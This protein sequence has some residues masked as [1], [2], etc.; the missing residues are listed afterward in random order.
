[1]RIVFRPVLPSDGDWRCADEN[2]HW[3]GCGALLS[4]LASNSASLGRFCTSLGIVGVVRPC[5]GDWE[6]S[7][8]V[9]LL[10]AVYSGASYT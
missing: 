7:A 1:M 8:L 9:G 10:A 2:L 6:G 3:R 4:G 5:G